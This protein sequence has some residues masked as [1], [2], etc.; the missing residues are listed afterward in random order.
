VCHL[1]QDSEIVRCD[2]RSRNMQLLSSVISLGCFGHDNG[3]SCSLKGPDFMTS[4]VTISFSN[5]NFLPR[6]DDFIP[7]ALYYTRNNIAVIDLTRGLSHHCTVYKKLVFSVRYVLWPKS[8][9]IRGG[10]GVVR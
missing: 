2:R 9:L 10:G 5:R 4:C 3:V 1:V 8:F 6:N 7:V